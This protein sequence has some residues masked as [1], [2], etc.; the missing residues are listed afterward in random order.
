MAHHARKVVIV[1]DSSKIGQVGHASI[2]P[3]SDIHVLVTDVGLPKGTHEALTSRG[4]QV[5]C[6]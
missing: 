4:I 6:A 5:V 1:A 3:I 2:C